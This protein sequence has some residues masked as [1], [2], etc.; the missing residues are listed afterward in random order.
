MTSPAVIDADTVRGLSRAALWD[1]VRNGNA[2]DPSALAD[3]EYH[4]T[5]LALPPLLQPFSWTKFFKVFQ[6]DGVGGVRGWNAAAEQN[7][8]SEPWIPK[9]RRD[10]PVSYWFYRVVTPEGIRLPAGMD[11][12]LV[13]DYATGGNRRLEPV[14]WVRDPLVALV[15][16]SVD[17]L[18]GYSFVALGPMLVHTPTFFLLERGA[19]LA[20]AAEPPRGW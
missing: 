15:P 14:N 10:R 6:S 20:W 8:F 16:G 19:P 7:A 18:L 12:G 4:G 2:I 3:R 13:I 1:R 17:L 9:T 11:R 5:A